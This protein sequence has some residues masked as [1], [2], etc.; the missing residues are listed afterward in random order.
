MSN[1][2]ISTIRPF[3]TEDLLNIHAY[4]SNEETTKYMLWGPNTL[5]DTQGFLNYVLSCYE[6]NPITHYEYG[7][8]Y[9]GNI[10]GGIALIVDY[11]TMKAEMG[12]I[13]HKDYQRRGIM[14][15]AA[16]QIIEFAKTLN[17]KTIYATADSRNVASYKLMEKL[18][19]HYVKTDYHVRLNKLTQQKD[20]DQVYYEMDL[21]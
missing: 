18:G 8:E 6:K 10:I 11:E 15:Q 17:I 5:E 3:K 20:L 14:Y 4:A 1:M 12:W 21:S 13:I 2:N 9:E 19:F 7:V 16:L